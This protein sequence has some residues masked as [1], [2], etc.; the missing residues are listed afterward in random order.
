[1]VSEITNNTRPIILT[2]VVKVGSTNKPQTN[3][4]DTSEPVPCSP[5]APAGQMATADPKPNGRRTP[6][7]KWITINGQ[8][9]I[10]HKLLFSKKA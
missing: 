3:S 10:P 2:P 6:L 1:M 7:N 5:A 8:A 4:T 9:L